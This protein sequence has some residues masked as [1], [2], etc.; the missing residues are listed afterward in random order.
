MAPEQAFGRAAEVD[1]R[2]DQYSLA[3]VAYEALSGQHP[4]AYDSAIEVLE[5]VRRHEAPLLSQIMPACPADVSRVIARAMSKDLTLRF[6]DVSEFARA[7]ESAAD[8]APASDVRRS[9]LSV[10]ATEELT[11]QTRDALERGDLASAC[12]LARSGA[13]AYAIVSDPRA[14]ALLEVSL[15]LF[16]HIFVVKSGGLEQRVCARP[17]IPMHGLTPTEAFVLS[18]TEEP[19]SIDELID[20]AGLPRVETLGIV[21]GLLDDGMLAAV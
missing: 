18:R 4:F 5:A 11:N 21:V 8:E 1:Q 6:D 17:G 16:E 19:L 9:T 2:A 12:R 10:D 7:L 3:L 14:R 15:P 13:K 20:V